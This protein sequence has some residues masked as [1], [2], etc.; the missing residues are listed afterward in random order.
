MSALYANGRAIVIDNIKE[1][2]PHN[3]GVT[4]IM[5]V[6]SSVPTLFEEKV[7]KIGDNGYPLVILPVKDVENAVLHPSKG[8]NYG[9]EAPIKKNCYLPGQPICTSWSASNSDPSRSG[10]HNLYWEKIPGPDGGFYYRSYNGFKGG[11]GGRFSVSLY[12][13][14]S[15]DQTRVELSDIPFQ[16]FSSLPAVLSA[17]LDENERLRQRNAVLEA[18]FLQLRDVLSGV[19]PSL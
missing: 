11:P 10:G 4:N 19:P 8:I 9:Q 5:L 6:D 3:Y 17:T 1:K 7:E 16:W 14:P 18:A 2:T 12:M 15:A 13:A